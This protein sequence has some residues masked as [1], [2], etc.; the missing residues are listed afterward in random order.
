MAWQRFAVPLKGNPEPVTVQTLAVDWRRVKLDPNA[1]LDGVWQAVHYALVRTDASVPRDY[2]G[3]LEVLD[4]MPEAL[5]DDG[6]AG[7]LDPTN[8]AP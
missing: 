8:A 7:P 2:E 4:G 3:F 5:D 1:P 6:E